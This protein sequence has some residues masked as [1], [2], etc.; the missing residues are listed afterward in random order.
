MARRG[1]CRGDGGHAARRQGGLLATSY[2][3]LGGRYAGRSQALEAGADPLVQRSGLR[4]AGPAHQLALPRAFARRPR[5]AHL[6][7]LRSTKATAAAP[8][9]RRTAAARCWR[10]RRCAT[11]RAGCAARS[12][13]GASRC[14]TPPLPASLT[15]PTACPGAAIATMP[16]TGCRGCGSTR[17]TCWGR[18]TRRGWCPVRWTMRRWIRPRRQCHRRHPALELPA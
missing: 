13:A 5:P 14:S 16:A 12:G 9:P 15:P 3:Y 8:S 10:S 2:G 11:A 7:R 17:R 4:R 1:G 6:P 18:S